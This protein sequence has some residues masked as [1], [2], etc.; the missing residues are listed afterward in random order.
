MQQMDSLEQ[1]Y[2]YSDPQHYKLWDGCE[3]MDIIKATLS[4][5]ELEGFY[6]GNILKYQLRMGRKPGQN[7]EREMAKIT[8][9][10]TYLEKLYI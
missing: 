10:Q 7:V 6:K 4:K 8:E 3:A 5:Q 1:Q 2:N 9:Y